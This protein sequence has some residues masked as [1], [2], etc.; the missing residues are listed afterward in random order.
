VAGDLDRDGW[1]D[2]VITTGRAG[3]QVVLRNTR[4]GRFTRMAAL[5]TPAPASS[6]LLV[7]VDLDGDLDVLLGHEQGLSLHRNDGQGRFS[8]TASASGLT[9]YEGD[10]RGL[11]AGDLDGDGDLDLVANRR[12]AAALLLVNSGAEASGWIRIDARGLSSNRSGLGTKIDVRAGRLHQKLEVTGAAGFLSQSSRLVTFGLRAHDAA[13]RV[14]LLWP[15]GV[16]QAEI[17][18]PGRTTH[19]IEELDRKGSS[20]PFLWSWNGSEIEFISDIQGGSPLGLWVAPG[21]R[22]Q[23]DPEEWFLLPSESVAVRDGAYDLRITESLEEVAY[24]DRAM[25]RVVDA[26]SGTQVFPNERLLL[27]PPFAEYGL[28]FVTATR[29]PLR[30]IDPDGDAR[31]RVASIDRRYGGATQPTRFRGIAEPWSLELDFGPIERT[32]GQRLLLLA[33]GWIEFSNST[34]MFA[35]SQAGVHI[36]PPQ[37]DVLDGVGTVHATIV[38]AGAPAGLPKWM[39]LDLTDHLPADGPVRLRYHTNMEIHFD[40]V[41][42]GIA[43]P[44]TPHVV[45][46]VEAETA[47]LSWTGYPTLWS[48]DG[49]RPQL[50]RRDELKRDETWQTQEGLYTRFGDVRALLRR[51]DDL[52]VVMSHGDELE[53]RFPVAD[54]PELDGDHTRHLILYTIGYAKDLD[55]HSGA[56]NSVGPLPY[57]SMPSYP[58]DGR[59]PLDEAE[60]ASRL[61]QWSTRYVRP[62]AG[63][64]R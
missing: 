62:T 5:H 1:P 58:Y 48:P 34:P 53:I 42:L 45:T 61:A 8:D 46:D 27:M 57:R 20:C 37:L 7:D 19:I 60:F 22:N 23:P 56:P 4:D 64:L 49:A 50:Y 26:P 15:G 28:H 51:G 18:R 40:Q 44:E 12:G 31:D 54:L 16:L 39:V 55:G 36:E 32:A 2:L 63:T 29:A 21:V 59:G 6:C 33:H 38:D 47:E 41:L 43:D 10:V 17:D 9:A 30:A 52:P 25:L 24:V 13:D 11:A 14:R 35:A 3:E